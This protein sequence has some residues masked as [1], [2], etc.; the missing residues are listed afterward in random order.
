MINLNKFGNNI[1]TLLESDFTQSLDSNVYFENPT[2]K[3]W[4][5][6]YDSVKFIYIFLLSELYAV[7][8]L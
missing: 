2:F 7:R 4:N 6:E 5:L 8:T 3:N 1:S